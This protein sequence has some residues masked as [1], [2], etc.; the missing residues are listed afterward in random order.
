MSTTLKRSLGTSALATHYVTSVMG[1]GV[2]VIPALAWAAAGP[3]SLVAWALLIVYSYPFALIFAK[4]SMLHPTSKGVAEFAEK[5]FGPSFGRI[6]AVFLLITLLVANPVLGLASGRY[7]LGAIVPDASNRASLVVGAVIILGCIALNLL[8]IRVSTTMQMIVLGTV[9]VLL[10]VVIALTVPKG[11]LSRLSPVAPNGWLSLGT[12]LLIC[13][14]GFIGWENAAPVAEEVRDPARTFPKAIL[15]AV[16]GV[17]V[18]YFAMALAVA[19]SLPSGL[20]S[21]AGLTGFVQLLKIAIGTQ[22]AGAGNIVAGGLMLLTT[23]AWCLGTSRV[24]FALARDGVLPVSL[25]H[26]SPRTRIPVRAVLALVPGYGAAVGL[27][28]LT[29]SNESALIKASS[30][31]FLLVFLVA[32][33]SALRLIRTG[34][35]R[36]VTMM[37]VGVTVVMLPFFGI[38]VAFAAVMFVVALIVE[39]GLRRRGHTSTDVSKVPIP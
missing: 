2:L 22:V 10:V 27:L 8:G 20:G 37:V 29:D 9:V 1:V 28:L 25:A 35:I 32:F 12:A 39:F 13:F 26:V 23:N 11:D 24:I 6:T 38:S 16:S 34:V 19:V 30:A 31:A 15:Y 33:I 4:L 5:A 18:L 14:F 7:L 3:L 36:Y 17:G 21:Q